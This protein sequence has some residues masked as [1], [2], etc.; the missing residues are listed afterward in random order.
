MEILKCLVIYSYF[1]FWF[2]VKVSFMERTLPS[3]LDHWH[4]CQIIRSQTLCRFDIWSCGIYGDLK[5]DLTREKK[6]LTLSRLPLSR[7]QIKRIENASVG[8][9]A[10]APQSNCQTL[11]LWGFSSILGLAPWVKDLALLQAAESVTDAAQIWCCC[12]CA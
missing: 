7:C 5:I 4:C 8:I 11:S 1:L 12:I 3:T 9:H 2:F 10:V 6:Y